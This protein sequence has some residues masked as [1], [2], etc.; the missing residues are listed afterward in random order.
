MN[1]EPRKLSPAQRMA[2]KALSRSR[3]ESVTTT[4]MGEI[5]IGKLVAM[6]AAL[7]GERIR[8][9]KPRVTDTQAIMKAVA[10]TLMEFPDLNAHFDDGM[11]KP[12][13]TV[14]LGMAVSAANGDLTVPVLRSVEK[15][16]LDEIATSARKLTAG[17]RQNRLS[18]QDVQG[19]GFTVSSVASFAAVRFATPI[20]PLPQVA[21]LAIGAVRSAPVVRDGAL[22]VGNVLPVS[23]A[24]DHRPINGAV[25]AQ[26][27]DRLEG[28]LHTPECLTH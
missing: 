14:N 27:L 18:I 24:F 5:E 8:A 11:L 10:L 7:N 6:L 23:L 19:A 9:E 20:L 22:S 12:F 16:T 1:F 2:A 21:I 15:M 26:F 25:A 3:D 4:V 13:D 28:I 17:A